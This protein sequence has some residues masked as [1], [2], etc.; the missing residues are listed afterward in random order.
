MAVCSELIN[1][2]YIFEDTHFFTQQICVII[3]SFVCCTTQRVWVL[4]ILYLCPSYPSQCGCPFIFSCRKIFSASLLVFLINS[5]STNSCNFGVSVRGGK[6]RVFLFCHLGHPL[7]YS[8]Y[9]QEIS[10][11]EASMPGV[12]LSLLKNFLFFLVVAL[13]F[14]IKTLST[15]TI[16]L[17]KTFLAVLNI[18]CS[19]NQNY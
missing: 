8:F 12:L 4:A 7:P 19:N 14:I 1:K 13:I 16:L 2:A 9:A 15:T 5:C 18:N 3:S 6:V 17:S 10:R 11:F